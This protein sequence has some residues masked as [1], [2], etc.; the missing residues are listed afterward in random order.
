VLY[1]VVQYGWAEYRASYAP[2]VVIGFMLPRIIFQMAFLT[3]IGGLASPDRQRFAFVGSSMQALSVAAVV[4]AA[5]DL[6]RERYD[7]TTAQIR[8]SEISVP[9]VRMAHSWVYVVEGLFFSVVGMLVVG[10]VLGYGELSL[11]LIALLPLY[12]VAAVSM[13]GFGLTVATLAPTDLMI[14][15]VNSA[16]AALLV[17]GGMVAP[18]SQLGPLDHVSHLLPGVNALLAIRAAVDGGGVAAWVLA[19]CGVAVLWTTVFLLADRVAAARVRG[20]LA[21]R[22]SD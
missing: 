19:E 10:P 2:S 21:G 1:R 15:L 16:N 9:L 20:G 8:L 18:L 11:H 3:F 6:Y 4:Y 22:G 5:I 7:G 13:L 12:A 14:V 17:L